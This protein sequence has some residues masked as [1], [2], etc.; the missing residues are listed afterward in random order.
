[1]EILKQ[2]LSIFFLPWAYRQHVHVESCLSFLLAIPS[3]FTVKVETF[4]VNEVED[5][6]KEKQAILFLKGWY[7]QMRVSVL[8]K[9]IKMR[10][11]HFVEV[12]V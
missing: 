8:S 9:W 10:F 4:E 2:N 11:A 5:F 12:F 6:I 3:A 1:M 7:L